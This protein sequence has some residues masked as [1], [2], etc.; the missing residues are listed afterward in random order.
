M[1]NIQPILNRRTLLAGGLL[2]P[3]LPSLAFA[4]PRSLTFAVLRNDT[5]IGEHHLSFASDGQALTA[6]TEAS[7]TVKLGPVPVFKYLH[8]A[9]ERRTDGVFASI[10]TS[11]R[12][13]GKS[14]HLSAENSGGVIRIDGTAGK[15]TAPAGSNPITHWNPA[16]FSGPLFDPQSGKM[17]KIKTTKVGAGHWEI[18]GQTEID[19]YYDD[20]GNWQALKGKL[21]DGS[22]VEYR[23]I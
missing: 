22:M 17:M 3:V 7:M 21:D 5:K 12:T 14:Q 20:T 4:A 13:N 8:R 16:I 11:T 19:D 18:R 15:L 10:E 2:L 9:V 1:P 23:R 6:T